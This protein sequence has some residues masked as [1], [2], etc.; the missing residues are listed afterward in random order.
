MFKFDFTEDQLDELCLKKWLGVPQVAHLI[1]NEQRETQIKI[2]NS[3][4]KNRF[5]LVNSNFPDSLV[6]HVKIELSSL[7]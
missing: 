2:A 3:L 5:Q 1:K 6:E 7:R 4:E